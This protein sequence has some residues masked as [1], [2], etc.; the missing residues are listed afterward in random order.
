[1]FM[2]A[3]LLSACSEAPQNN[4]DS[5]KFP[6]ANTI[7]SADGST[8]G[9]DYLETPEPPLLSLSELLNASDVK[10]ALAIAAEQNDI[11]SLRMWQE[12]LLD[13]ADEVNLA[14]NEVTLLSG[15]RGLR[16]LAFQGMKANYQTAFERAFFAFEDVNQVYKDYPA[17][18][19]LHKRSSELVKQRD[20]LVGKVS[21]ELEASDF[22]GDAFEEAKRQWQNFV[23]TESALNN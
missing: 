17:F 20:E 11:D 1:M 13:A 12:T 18:E 22:E 4:H 21:A 9:N 6:Q 3:F 10:Q 5:N 8:V 16:Y 7:V 19:D 15:E 2:C 23:L 14:S